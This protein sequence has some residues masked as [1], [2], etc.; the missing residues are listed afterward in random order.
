MGPA[1]ET[2]KVRPSIMTTGEDTSTHNVNPEIPVAM[3]SSFAVGV[4]FIYSNRFINK[5][6]TDYLYRS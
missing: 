4:S 5:Y 6:M 2:A 3:R 1:V